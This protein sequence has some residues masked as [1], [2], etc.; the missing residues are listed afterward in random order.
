MTD[1]MRVHPFIYHLFKTSVRLAL[2]LI[3]FGIPIAAYYLR[4]HGIGFGAKEA[5]C[6][7]LSTPAVEVQI[8]RLALDPFKGLFAKNI[9]VREKA[10]PQRS[11]ANLSSLVISVNISE[12]MHGRFVVDRLSLQNASASIPISKEENA[13]RLNAKDINAEVIWLGDRLRL[14]LF[15]GVVD[16]IRV[17]LSGEILNPLSFTPHQPPSDSA[18]MQNHLLLQSFSSALA[19]TRFLS[20]APVLKAYFEVDASDLNS[21]QIPD[22]RINSKQF[23]F[24]TWGLESVEI[25]G[26][27]NE[28]VLRLPLIRLRDKTGTFQASAQW[29]PAAQSLAM[30]IIS[31]LNPSPFL[32]SYAPAS[33]P[34]Q[35]LHFPS[36]PRLEADLKADLSPSVP[37]IRVT[38]N[39]QSPE[40]NYD[41]LKFSNVGYGF[42]YGGGVFYARD[43]TLSSHRGEITANLWIAKDDI[44]LSLKNSIPPSDLVS[45]VNPQTRNFL[46]K[47]EFKDLPQVTLTLT[48]PKLDFASMSGKGHI[49]LGRTAMRE[50]WIDN[51]VADFE[52]SDQCVT[53]KNIVINTGNGRGTGMF[54][55]DVGR[56]EVRLENI[57]STLI[58]LDLMMWIDPK[59]AKTITPYRFR[60]APY[61]TVHGK[62]H[63]RDPA[64]NALGINV[65]APGLDYDLLGKTLSF[66]RTTA[67]VDVVSNKV[68]ADVKKAELMGGKV[69]VKAHVSVIPT[70]PT[71]TADVTLNRVNFSKLTN[72]YFK[73]DDSKGVVSGRYQFQAR[74]G[75][76][77][78]MTGTGNIRVEDGN[79]FA[80]PMF[81]PFSYILG[82]ILPGVAYNT[83]RFATADFTA[84]NEKITSNNIEIQGTGFGM[85]GSGDIYFLT[86]G[87]DMSMRINAKGIPGVVFFPVSKLFEYY[88]NGTISEPHWY[89][90]IIPRI[91]IFGGGSKKSTTP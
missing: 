84:A 52:I 69:A 89:P 2:V 28:G 36:P 60:S 7:A 82:S 32:S 35:K 61:V 80:I 30:S 57:K 67:R 16:G 31:T 41:E 55:Y 58:P 85:Y 27:Y 23:T 3:F 78:Q 63:M 18:G 43:L 51:G 64:K 11:L 56:Q 20:A 4:V 48:M 34:L 38:G 59:I 46:E 39:F 17:H 50:S 91:P 73:Y 65:D 75:Q 9:V 79:V 1:S 54:A 10:W 22:I 33:S 44:R 5:L 49:K 81:G 14:S 45:L 68:I 77:S 71:F 70:D 37:E 26:N 15:D 74:M 24:R 66:G 90:K 62:V 25:E 40:L 42:S 47:M 53:Y 21:L 12:L 8:E 6:D 19:E 29:N 76:E 86:G 83:A 88:S 87:L 72:L 13:A